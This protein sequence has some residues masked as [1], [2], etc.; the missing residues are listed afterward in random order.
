VLERF[1][2]DVTFEMRTVLYGMHL[3][4]DNVSK[5]G[6]HIYMN[7]EEGGKEQDSR[8]TERERESV[9][10]RDGAWQREEVVSVVKLTIGEM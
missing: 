6:H 2:I 1:H 3:F 4:N 5:H 9:C 10:E 8:E 7:R